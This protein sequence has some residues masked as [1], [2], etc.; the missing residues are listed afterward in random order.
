MGFSSA[1]FTQKTDDDREKENPLFTL[2]RVF[3]KVDSDK[4]IC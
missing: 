1:D 2:Q 3:L 4:V